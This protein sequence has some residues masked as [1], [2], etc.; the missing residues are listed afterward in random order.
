[1][2]FPLKK[3]MNKPV[4]KRWSHYY[5]FRSYTLKVNASL[6]EEGTAI[7]QSED[8]QSK[9]FSRIPYNIKFEV[10]KYFKPGIIFPV[11]VSES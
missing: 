3:M 9:Q 11:K 8:H 6:I 10:P 4:Q 7:K 5:S 2:D 1:M